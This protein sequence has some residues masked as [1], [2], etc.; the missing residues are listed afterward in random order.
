MTT[1]VV[2]QSPLRVL[3]QAAARLHWEEYRRR[4]PTPVAV[5]RRAPG[6]RRWSRRAGLRWAGVL[7]TVVLPLT[8]GAFTV[9]GTELNGWHQ[10]TT[11]RLDGLTRAAPAPRARGVRP[12]P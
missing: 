2:H 4:V 5:G 8:V 11:H 7:P 12:P 1:I 9:V 6:G 10:S 3:P